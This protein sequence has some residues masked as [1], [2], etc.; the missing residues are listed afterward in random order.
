MKHSATLLSTL[1]STFCRSTVFIGASLFSIAASAHDFS[2]GDIQIG[3]PFARATIAQQTAGGAY[4]SLHN[5]GK[6]DDQLVKVSSSVAKKGE[7]HNMEMV[8]DVMKMRAIDKIE[9]KAGSKISMQPGGGY[10]IMLI[11]L[12]RTLKAGE[13]FPL[14][15]EFAK[16][17]KID[18]TVN[19][20]AITP[21][22]NNS[23]HA[24]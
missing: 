12:N 23:D 24:H 17:G 18:V 7:I 3:H 10:H 4:L 16:A 22:A 2:L 20:E 19:V 21:N 6:S 8:G 15:L 11:G 1:F 14:T 9:V 13:Q 5:V